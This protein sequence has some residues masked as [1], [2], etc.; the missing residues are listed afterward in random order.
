MHNFEFMAPTTVGVAVQALSDK[1]G[2]SEVLMGGTDTVSLLK[3]RIYEPTRVVSLS[4]IAGLKGAG[5]AGS[6]FRIGSMTSLASLHSD[7]TVQKSFPALV[8][9]IEGITSPQHRAMSTV[10]SDLLQ[11]PRCWYFRQGFG[12]LGQDD[13]GKSLIPKGENRYHAILGNKGPAYFVN[14]SSLAPVLMALD[15]EATVQGPE[16][17]RQIPVADLYQIPSSADERENT[18]KPNEVLTAIL[19]PN[20]K[21]AN[22]TYEVRQR[23]LFDWPLATA[24]V[25]LDM[26]G[27]KVRGATVVMGHV[28]PQPWRSA[29]AE[30]ALE[31]K[32]V[33]EETAAAAAKAAVAAA[34]PLSQNKHKVTLASVAV[35]RAIL[36]AAGM[37]A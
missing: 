27:G 1:P 12:L 28:A 3:E 25:S 34:T 29:E 36:K 2:V 7:K 30:S 9:A 13:D 8:E 18:L 14:A 5:K 23:Q 26:K 6:N 24:S 17:S 22:A 11:R 31:G 15:A 20:S 16:G 35:K 19:I 37:G 32:A 33:S 10:G 4:R 21:A